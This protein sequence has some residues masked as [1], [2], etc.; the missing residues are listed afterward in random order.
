M[1]E[2]AAPFLVGE[3]VRIG[4]RWRLHFEAFEGGILSCWSP[5]PPERELSGTEMRRYKRA[6]L[7]FAQRLAEHLGTSVVVLDGVPPSAGKT[8]H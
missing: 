5:R 6:R 8:L 7:A 4:K 3:E 1:S 2:E